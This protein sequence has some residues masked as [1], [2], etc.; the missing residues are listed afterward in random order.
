MAEPRVVSLVPAATEI[1]RHLGV[2]PVAISHCCEA[3]G[4]GAPIATSSIVPDGLAQAETDRIVS[5]AVA[6]G[7]SLYRVDE[8]LLHRLR[9]DLIVTQG[10]CEVCAAGP[11]E[12]ARAAACLPSAVPTLRLDGTR[13]AHLFDDLM[14]VAAATGRSAAGREAVARLRARLEV[15][16]AAVAGRQ[17]P[18]T[19][20]IEWLDPPFLGGHW[21]PD[22]LAAASAAPIGPPGGEASPRTTWAAIAAERPDAAVFAFCGYTL[23]ATMADVARFRVGHG[24][25]VPAGVRQDTIAESPRPE[26]GPLVVARAVAMDARYTCQLTPHAVRGVEI[27]AALLHP[28][29]L[30][31]PSEWEAAVLTLDVHYA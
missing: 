22:M 20:F 18:R 4:S 15:V 13:L 26:I 8:A 10:V 14:L 23:A 11:G 7:E 17:S 28:G 21:V 2:E 25:T 31:P 29:T 1:L 27:L 5:E 16:E 12:V 6:R 9:P 30:S 19:A 24:R 3:N